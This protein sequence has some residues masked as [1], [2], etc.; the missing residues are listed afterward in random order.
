MKDYFSNLS[1]T[2]KVKG[3]MSGVCF[4]TDDTSK[5]VKMKL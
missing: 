4:Q 5:M 3:N 1:T 2:A